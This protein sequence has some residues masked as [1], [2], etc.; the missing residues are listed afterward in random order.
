MPFT[1]GLLVGIGETREQR[2]HDLVLLRD[3]MAG[4]EG[5]EPGPGLAASSSLPLMGG[6]V[7]LGQGPIQE[8]I[9]QPFRAKL[10]RPDGPREA[11]DAS[12]ELLR[13]V[14]MARIILGP[15]A[16]V[17]SPPN[18]RLPWIPHC[19]ALCYARA[20]PEHVLLNNAVLAHC[21]LLLAGL[22]AAVSSSFGCRDAPWPHPACVSFLRHTH[23]WYSWCTNAA[24]SPEL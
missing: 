2:M 11:P 5:L 1:T 6:G 15:H 18:L 9:I 14:C 24:E 21:L 8:V 4:P 17:Q 20:Q 7:G 22:S 23:R 19:F 3:L 13:T 16:N 10:S 12:Q